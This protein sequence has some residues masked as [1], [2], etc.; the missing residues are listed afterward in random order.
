ML[1]TFYQL[2]PGS[3]ARQRKN[4]STWNGKEIRSSFFYSEGIKKIISGN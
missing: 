1:P 2:L 3:I 4:A